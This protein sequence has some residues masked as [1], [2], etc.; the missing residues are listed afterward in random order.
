MNLSWW[1]WTLVL[2]GGYFVI[3]F[4][5][6]GIEAFRAGSHDAKQ[7]GAEQSSYDDSYLALEIGLWPIMVI[8]DWMPMLYGRIYKFA[9]NRDQ[10][11]VARLGKKNQQRALK[12][13]CKKN[14][15]DYKRVKAG[16]QD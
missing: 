3:G 6:A 9:K 14:G 15:W 12:D 5:A 2:I 7:D 1:E 4:F 13:L 10:R 11:R 8:S 16:A